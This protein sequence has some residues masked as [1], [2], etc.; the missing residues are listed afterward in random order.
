MTRARSC[1]VCGTPFGDD[2]RLV[3]MRGRRH[4]E[5][6]SEFCLRDTM[7]RRWKANAA[8]KLR[9]VLR[10]A[11]V[12]LVLAGGHELWHRFRL[13]ES[14]AISYEPPELRR[15]PTPYEGPVEYG[16]AWPPTDPERIDLF[17]QAKWVYPL[18]GPVRRPTASDGG[19]FGA[20]PP[21]GHPATAINTVT[22][23]LDGSQVY[24][25]D[26]ATAASLRTA[27]GHMKVSAGDNLPIVETSQGPA[28][29]A[30]DV[31]AQENPDLTAL[32]TLFV[33]EHNYQVDQLHKEHPN[34]N[35]DKLYET[36]KAI[37]TAEIANI[38]YNEFLP[39]L[40]GP[41]AINPHRMTYKRLTR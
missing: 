19:V 11:L 23:W 39:H 22:G 4:E 7:H 20:E 32:Q 21:K 28:F 14:H 6:C 5:F 12:G 34:W 37:T 25:S 16:P 1:I 9:W 17:D 35:G 2:D 30:G 36:A 40:L 26:P 29:A 10:L 31:R 8:A 38:T 41:D 15:A 18:P 24:G 33:R 27:D 13:P 3:L